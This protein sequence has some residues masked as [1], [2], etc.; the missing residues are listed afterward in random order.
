[1]NVL[2]TGRGTSGS[3]QIRGV[4]L[5]NAIGAKVLPAALDVGGYDLAA[6]VK[7]PSPGL[8]ER[9]HR[10]EVRIVFDVV[11]AWPQPAG[12]AWA[13]VECMAWL[14]DQVR[15]IRPVAI[16]AATRQMAA[17]CAQFGVPVLWLPHH[18]R[19]SQRVNPIRHEVRTVGYEG[20]EQY[21]G[22]WS[23][24]LQRECARRGWRFVVNPEQLAD[25][26]IVVAI[27]E[28]T[29]YA[30]RH[31]KSNVKLANA[32]ATG[33]PFIG[34]REAG[35]LETACG[36]EHWADTDEEMVEALDALTPRESRSEASGMLLCAAPRLDE[37]APKYKEWL[38]S[39]HA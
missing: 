31:W 15:A 10:A 33:T 16:V 2:I 24:V 19:P 28:A 35:Y 21:L 26:D 6:L 37:L 13:Q 7:R 38:E 9:L 23:S 3:F 29:G 14:A 27:R 5:G 32:Q 18:A 36:A 34:C 22:R 4:Q 11:D 25:L 20:G 39:L 17:D 8:I 12:N 30:P 1:M